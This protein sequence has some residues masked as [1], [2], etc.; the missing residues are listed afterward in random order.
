MR[1][2]S[3]SRQVLNLVA[4]YTAISDPSFMTLSYEANLQT[5]PL[6]RNAFLGRRIF[7]SDLGFPEKRYNVKERQPALARSRSQLSLHHRRHGS[8]D[9]PDAGGVA[10]ALRHGLFLGPL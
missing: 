7:H 8:L 6:Q 1:C 2:L 9:G 5:V 3:R 10:P 4:L